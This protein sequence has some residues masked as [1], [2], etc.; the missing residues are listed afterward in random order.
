MFFPFVSV[1][2]DCKP[3][4][5]DLHLK[6]SVSESEIL[7]TTNRSIHL[8]A[9]VTTSC[10]TSNQTQYQWMFC[11]TD[12]ETNYFGTFIM[13]A[14]ETIHLKPRMFGPGIVYVSLL[15]KIPEV[16]GTISYDYG[17]LRI[18]Q[19]DLVA[20]IVAPRTVSKRDAD[21]KLNSSGSYDP[22]FKS[23]RYR[24]LKFT[25]RCQRKCRLD[26]LD[27]LSASRAEVE[28]CYGIANL[29]DSVFSSEKVV[30]INVASFK[31]DC[32]YLFNLSVAKDIRITH[33]EH[34][35]DV[36]PAITFYIR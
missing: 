26:P 24:R 6:H 8:I 11:S 22:E 18:H 28:P 35:L 34:A 5:V 32:T 29:T 13:T 7:Y 15:V 31:S 16:P 1:A 36:T 30:T 3:P 17:F 4:I 21:V 9:E 33:A 20:K 19:P 12:P 2:C 25:W 14:S 27:I 23:L 10:S